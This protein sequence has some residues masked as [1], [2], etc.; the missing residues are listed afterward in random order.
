MHHVIQITCIQRPQV[1]QLD[2]KVSVVAQV[3]AFLGLRSHK[4]KQ[5]AL[6]QISPQSID[7]KSPCY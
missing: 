2:S 6:V 3:N 4:T 1:L 5:A 7:L